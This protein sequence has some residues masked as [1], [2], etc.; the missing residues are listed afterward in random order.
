MRSTRPV[1][2][3]DELAEDLSKMTADE[4]DT[5]WRVRDRDYLSPGEYL[6]WCSYLTRGISASREDLA[7]DEHLPF[8]LLG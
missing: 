6:A 8:E 2:P 3:L 1:E 5:L 7:S 4:N